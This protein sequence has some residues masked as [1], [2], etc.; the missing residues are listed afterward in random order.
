MNA[1][2]GLLLPAGRTWYGAPGGAG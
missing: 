1:I 2:V